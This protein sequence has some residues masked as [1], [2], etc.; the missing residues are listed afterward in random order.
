ME[1]MAGDNGVHI[2]PDVLLV[3]PDDLAQIVEATLDGVVRVGQNPVQNTPH[4]ILI[5]GGHYAPL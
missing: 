5:D 2:V 1:I 3:Q 4:R